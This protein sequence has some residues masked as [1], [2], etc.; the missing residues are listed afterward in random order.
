MEDGKLEL[1]KKGEISPTQA[2][3]HKYSN[4][5]LL[6]MPVTHCGMESKRTLIQYCLKSSCFV[7]MSWDV[8][9]LWLVDQKR[10][11]SESGPVMGK[12]QAALTL[13]IAASFSY[14]VCDI[15]L[16]STMNSSTF[17]ELCVNQLREQPYR[18]LPEMNMKKTLWD[19][20]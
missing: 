2:K 8:S 5:Q 10:G 4:K 6:L 14:D 3:H 12:C 16:N 18:L 13:S 1:K 9:I 20:P 7:D 11:T 19:S 15:L 17:L